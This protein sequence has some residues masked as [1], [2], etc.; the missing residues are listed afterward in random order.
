MHFNYL[1]INTARFEIDNRCSYGHVAFQKYENSKLFKNY[2][3]SPELDIFKKEIINKCNIDLK[4]YVTIHVRDS[5]FYNDH[6]RQTRN[7]NINKYISLISKIQNLG[8]SV[9]KLGDNFSIKITNFKKINKK[10]YFDYASSELKNEINDIFFISNA[11]FHIGTPSG[12]SFIP[13]IFNIN[14]YWTTCEYS[15][16]VFGLLKR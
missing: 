15:F 1:T 10:M 2:N 16:P 13:M 3:Q 5:G 6:S 9:V 8:Y 14:T 4:N 12:L 11:K 7:A